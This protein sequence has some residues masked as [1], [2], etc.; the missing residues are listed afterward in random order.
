MIPSE[1]VIRILRLIEGPYLIIY[2]QFLCM[3]ITLL[4]ILI[5]LI[6]LQAFGAYVPDR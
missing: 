2:V 6:V 3:T 5:F 4:Q 1:V